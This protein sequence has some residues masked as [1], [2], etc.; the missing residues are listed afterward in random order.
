MSQLRDD[1]VFSTHNLA[2]DFDFGEMNVVL[3]RNVM[4]YFKSDLK[5]KGNRSF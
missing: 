3:C 2:T 5:E 4:I 1:I